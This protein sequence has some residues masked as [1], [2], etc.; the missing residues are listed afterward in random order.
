MM[1]GAAPAAAT[2]G[3]AKP[4]AKT[5]A[6][7]TNGHAKEDDAEPGEITIN[8]DGKAIDKTTGRFVPKD[9]ALRWKGEAKEA[10]SQ[11]DTLIKSVVQL[12]ERLA[13]LLEPKSDPTKAQTAEEKRIDPTEDYFGAYNQLV[14]KVSKLESKLAETSTETKGQLEARELRERFVQDAQRFTGT[15]KAFPAAYQYLIESLHTELEAEGV[16]DKGERDRQIAENIRDR[17]TRLLRAGKSPAQTIWAIAKSRG[18][19]AKPAV[20]P[21]AENEAKAKAELD[22]INRAKGATHTLN[23]AGSSGGGEALT[24]QKLASLAGDDYGAQ[25]RAYIAKHGEHAWRQLIG[26]A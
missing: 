10:K 12:Q 16:D 9:V 24:L 6:P 14:E 21:N 26:G 4:E 1:D 2:N 11:N 15:E 22:R 19:Q 23:G 25:R 8:A 5:E 3:E 20:D 17:A 18:F 13:T 7:K